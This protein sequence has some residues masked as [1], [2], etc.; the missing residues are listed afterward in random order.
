MIS[1]LTEIFL[2]TGTLL[3]L[4][5]VIFIFIPSLWF[6]IPILL[7]LGFGLIIGTICLHAK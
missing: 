2:Y 7:P 5:T 3:I 4:L 6:T 1:T